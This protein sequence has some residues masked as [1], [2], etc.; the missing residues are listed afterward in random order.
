LNDA[1]C[2][3]FVASVCTDAGTT[4]KGATFDGIDKVS[5]SPLRGTDTG[6]GAAEGAADEAAATAAFDGAAG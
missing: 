6:S 5:G 2:A 4:S 1:C 3:A